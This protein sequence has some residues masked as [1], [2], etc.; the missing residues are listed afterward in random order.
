MSTTIATTRNVPLRFRGFLASCMLEITPGVYVAP[1]LK[2][3]V[4]ERIWD[5]MLE[6]SEL[7]D[8]DAGVAFFWRSRR[9]PSGLGMKLIGWPQKE[10]LEQEGVWL[11]LRNL[12]EAHDRDE[13]EELLDPDETSASDSEAHP[14]LPDSHELDPR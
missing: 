5:V 1:R 4:R 11:A 10:L 13:L 7:L 6:W 8:S 14:E 12:T 3:S 9:T 2:K